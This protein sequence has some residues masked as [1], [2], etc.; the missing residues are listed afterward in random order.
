MHTEQSVPDAYTLFVNSVRNDTPLLVQP[1]N[2][3]KVMKILD[4]IYRS[5][6]SGEPEKIG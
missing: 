5:A 2:G 6:K 3:V 1:G 4:A